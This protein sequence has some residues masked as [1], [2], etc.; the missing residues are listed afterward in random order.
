MYVATFYFQLILLPDAQGRIA[1]P[2]IYIHRGCRDGSPWFAASILTQV[3]GPP[4]LPSAVKVVALES[5]VSVSPSD[6]RATWKDCA[7][8]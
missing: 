1:S 8:K 6:T 2:G 3:S 7:A 5:S 4:S